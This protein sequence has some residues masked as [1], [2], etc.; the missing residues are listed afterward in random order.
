MITE[1]DIQQKYQ[2]LRNMGL[3]DE[4]ARSELQLQMGQ[5]QVIA[6]QAEAQQREAANPRPAFTFDRAE[7]IDQMAGAA[8]MRGLDPLRAAQIQAEEQRL[9]AAITALD[10]QLLPL[11]QQRQA[12]ANQLARLRFQG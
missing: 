6:A 1:Q 2:R 5:A 8:V 12:L 4:A 7:Y 10:G 11:Q 3:S 9:I